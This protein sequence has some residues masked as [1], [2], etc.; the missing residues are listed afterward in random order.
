[1]RQFFFFLIFFSAFGKDIHFFFIFS[2]TS[3]PRNQQLGEK[4]FFILSKALFKKKAQYFY[5]K[6]NFITPQ[7]YLY[8]K[9]GSRGVKRG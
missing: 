9:K 8:L 5:R 1:M 4:D 2:Y 6:K 3:S 7:K